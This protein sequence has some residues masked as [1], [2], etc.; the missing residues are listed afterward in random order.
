M[1]ESLEAPSHKRLGDPRCLSSFAPFG[2]IS[3]FVLFPS[4]RLWQFNYFTERGE[5]LLELE[6]TKEK[7]QSWSNLLFWVSESLGNEQLLSAPGL[8]LTNIRN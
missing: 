4:I 3:S 2:D 1:V 5:M 6:M 8:L 7:L